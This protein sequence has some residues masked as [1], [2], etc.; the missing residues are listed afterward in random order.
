MTGIRCKGGIFKPASFD[1]Q[2]GHLT[3]AL[4]GR[5]VRPQLLPFRVGGMHGRADMRTTRRT[6]PRERVIS[7]DEFERLL[8]R[9]EK[10]QKLH[11][12]QMLAKLRPA[13]KRASAA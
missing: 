8:Q 6:M 4:S 13:R 7:P 3:L 2:D 11:G 1:Q 10:F 5:N 9:A 12:P